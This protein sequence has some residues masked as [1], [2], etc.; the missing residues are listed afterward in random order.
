MRIKNTDFDR[1][2]T[3]LRDQGRLTQKG[4]DL[5]Y[6]AIPITGSHNLATMGREVANKVLDNANN[7]AGAPALGSSTA[8]VLQGQL[9]EFLGVVVPDVKGFQ[10]NIHEV[11]AESFRISYQKKEDFDR[12]EDTG[13]FFAAQDASDLKKD[14]IA[15]EAKEDKDALE[16]EEERDASIGI[17]NNN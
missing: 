9:H 15:D 17:R 7:E 13:E 11:L 10:G 3:T 16:D 6:A 4:Y 2:L 5:V 8:V 14:S 12:T 1:F